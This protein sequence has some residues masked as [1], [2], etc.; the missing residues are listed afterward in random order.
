MKFLVFNVKYSDNL[1]DGLLAM[2]LEMALANEGTDTKVQTL[3]I[4]GR[5]T[6]GSTSTRRAGAIKFIQR[7]PAFVRRIAIELILRRNLRRLSHR[8]DDALKSA[9]AVVIGGGNL[10]QDDDLNFPLKI[11]VVLDCVS[12]SGKPLVIHA[13]GVS[14]H[15]SKRARQLFGRLDATKVASISVRDDISRRNWEKHFPNGPKPIIRPDPGLLA[16]EL[17]LPEEYTSAGGGPAKL[18]MCVTA[19]F[20]LMRHANIPKAAIPL[21]TI[22]GYVSLASQ[23]ITAGYRVLLFSNG[24]REDQAFAELVLAHSGLTRARLDGSLEIAPRPERPEDLLLVLKKVSAIAAHRLHACIAAYSLNIPCVGLDWDRKM[25]GFFRSI[26]REQYCLSGEGIRSDHVFQ[27]LLT[28]LS[29]GIDPVLHALTLAE[30]R[31]GVASIHG[32]VNRLNMLEN[33]KDREIRRELRGEISSPNLLDHA[34]KEGFQHG[35]VQ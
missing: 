31:S 18:G 16:R 8:Y 24:A 26:D 9:D 34:A 2:C 12:R 19:P 33:A 7:L 28:A 25:S 10:F 23:A 20:I 5:T 14:G 11:A 3:D 22:E 6:F 30:A 4:A 13:V 17:S 29:K 1:G 21:Q 32:A 35:A 15:W 27:S